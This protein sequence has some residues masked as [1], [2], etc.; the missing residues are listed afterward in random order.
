VTLRKKRKI[1]NSDQKY[2]TETWL[3]HVVSD[4]NM[5]SEF[6][7]DDFLNVMLDDML[8]LCE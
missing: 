7:V 5:Y 8:I 6:L 1:I 2:F 4:Q 3:K